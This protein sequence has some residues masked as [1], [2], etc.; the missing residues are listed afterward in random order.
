MF[1]VPDVTPNTEE[2]GPV[3]AEEPKDFMALKPMNCPAHV[4][5]FKQGIKSYKD[6]P[7]RMAEF[8]CCHRNEA[9]GA[10]HGF[11]RVRQ[12]TQD[13]GHI[14]CR[15]DQILQEAIEFCQLAKKV[16]DDL[17]FTDYYLTIETRPEE[18]IGSDEL[19]D[20]AEDGLKKAMDHLGLE[21]Q[22]AEGDGAFYGPKLGFILKDAIGREWGCATL[23]LDFNLPMRFEAT[24]VG[25]DGERHYPVMLHRAILGTLERFIGMMIEQYAG[26]LPTWLAPVQAVVAN[27]TLESEAYALELAEELTALGLRVETDFRNEKIGYKIREHSVKKVPYVFVVGAKEM[28]ER[29]VA[30]RQLGGK[31]QTMKTAQ[32]AINDL[33]KEAKAPY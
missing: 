17:G 19:W 28:E 29:T 2:D 27:I 30:I 20:K 18:R 1:V 10:L 25:E 4:E 15:E 21:Y 32:D 31:D 8:G 23:Q 12:F 6:L 9:H 3:F 7:I 33:A 26:K 22:I 14:F 16:Y 13:D 24:Y 11:L 5:I